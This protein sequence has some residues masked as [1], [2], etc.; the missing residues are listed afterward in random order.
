VFY[1]KKLGKHASLNLSINAIVVLI[2]AVTMLGLGLGFIKRTFSKATAGLE[3]VQEEIKKQLIDEL[4]AST[5]RLKFDKFDIVLKAGKTKIVYFGVKNDIDTASGC[6]SEFI[7]SAECY[8]S[9][10]K[11]QGSIGAITL[12]TILPRKIGGGQVEV[13]KMIISTKSGTVVDT[14]SCL[15]S[16]KK[17]AS[18]SDPGCANDPGSD[19]YS[20]KEFFVTIAS[21]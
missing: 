2:L 4:R 21:G 16:V 11:V 5:E 13:G 17:E 14:Y 1:S 3:E 20:E 12:A 15:I 10:K 8:D 19:P 9:L 6:K 7:S 18:P